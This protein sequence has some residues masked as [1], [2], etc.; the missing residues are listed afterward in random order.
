MPGHADKKRLDPARS[1]E[2]LAILEE[3]FEGSME[4]HPTIRW[5]SVRKRIEETPAKLWSLGEMER[6]GGEPDVVEQDRATG[7]YLF[8]HC[9]PESPAGRRSLCYDDEA[10]EARK[11]HKPAASAVGTANA[12]RAT[13]LSEDQYRQLQEL[14]E[15]DTRT[16]SWLL[17]SPDI[18][19]R[20]GAIFGDFRYGRVFV[21]HN[22]AESY[23]AGRG[24]RC[25]V[26][27]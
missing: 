20:G 26:R 7:E 27:V 17:T 5:A 15:F 18:R 19:T 21:Y 25:V 1:V 10:L 13:L 9:S 24:F 2:L 14:G 12:M 11:K 16:S 4:R 23:Y 8:Y 3:R 22:G 6:T